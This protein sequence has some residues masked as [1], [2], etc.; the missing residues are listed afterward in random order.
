[1]SC[2][3]TLYMANTQT[4]VLAANSVISFG[5]IIRRYG[6]NITGT[7]ST[8]EVT[9]QGYFDVDAN[10]SILGTG[11]G[12]AIITL[13]KDGVAIPGATA[14]ITTADTVRNQVSIPCLIREKCCCASSI[15]A[16]L[17][18]TGATITNAAIVV[19]K[20]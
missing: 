5:T 1:M 16:V 18:G 7:D 8:V 17:S 14:T 11:T 4:Q 12:T 2:R 20:V 9:G 15:T 10:F 13:Y 3:S 6:Q 19:E